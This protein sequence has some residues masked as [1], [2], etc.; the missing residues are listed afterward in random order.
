MRR[1]LNGLFWVVAITLCA[2]T[3][4]AQEAQTLPALHHPVGIMAPDTIKIPSEFPLGKQNELICDSCHGIEGLE[5]IP[6]DEVDTEEPDFLRFGPYQSL[7]DFCYHCHEE[8]GHERYNLHLMIDE[9]GQIDDS[10]CIYCHEETPDPSVVDQADDMVFRLPKEKLCYGCHLKTPHL[11]AFIH[12]VE[13]DE[14]IREMMRQSQKK[15]AVKL[16]LDDQGRIG[17]ITCHT[18]HQAGVIDPDRPAGKQVE[19]HPIDKGIVYR[20][21]AWSMVF[22]QDKAKRLND[23]KSIQQQTRD[24]PEY[25]RVDKEILLRLSAKDGSLCLSC[26]EFED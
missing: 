4:A 13:P 7:T 6:L 26:H 24:M 5:Q 19:D 22:A 9:Q 18:P 2:E 12:H 16:P 11:N 20:R 3:K 8:Q 23:L 17:C 15:Y 10:G 14:K 21:T 25:Q 1:F